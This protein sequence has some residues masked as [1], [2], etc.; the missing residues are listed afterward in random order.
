MGLAELE[1][2]FESEHEKLGEQEKN[3]EALEA[4]ARELMECWREE[5]R[6]AEINVLAEK[7][8]GAKEEEMEEIL[9]KIRDLQNPEI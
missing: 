3:K 1:L 9:R 7:L 4:E 5:K 8:E 2:V 6:K